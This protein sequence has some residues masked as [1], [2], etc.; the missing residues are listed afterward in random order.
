MGKYSCPCP[1]PK[2]TGKRVRLPMPPAQIV[3]IV[4]SIFVAH[5]GLHDQ[6]TENTLAAFCDAWS[7]GIQWCECDIHLSADNQ[8]VVI[9]DDTLERTP[10]GHGPVSAYTLSQL[11]FFNV[12][13]LHEV[14]KAM[15][16]AGGLLVEYK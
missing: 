3:L 13:S 6:F 10:S 1:R 11:R 14:I 7:K 4:M 5:R 16:P 9:H 15:P 8:P 12:P 2:N